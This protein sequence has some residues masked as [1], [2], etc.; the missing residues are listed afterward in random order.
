MARL[1]SSER[2]YVRER[3]VIIIIVVIPGLHGERIDDRKIPRV[4]ESQPIVRLLLAVTTDRHETRENTEQNVPLLLRSARFD[5]DGRDIVYD[6]QQPVGY[7]FDN[8]AML[9][10]V[11]HHRDSVADYLLLDSVRWSSGEYSSWMLTRL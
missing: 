11:H 4:L 5:H 10:A 6:L 3:C 8:E 7:I 9:R 2:V 1:G